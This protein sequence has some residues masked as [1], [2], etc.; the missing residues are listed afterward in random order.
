MKTLGP[1]HIVNIHDL[2]VTGLGILLIGSDSEFCAGGDGELQRITR[3]GMS[4]MNG[5]NSL[6]NSAT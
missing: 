2:I 3:D 4:G 1:T 5:S 6:Y